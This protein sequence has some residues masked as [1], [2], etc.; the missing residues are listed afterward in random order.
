MKMNEMLG[1]VTLTAVLFGLLLWL[2][3]G[4]GYGAT[5]CAVVDVAKTVCDTTPVRYL[6]PDGKPQTE[7]VPTDEIRALAKRTRAARMQDAGANP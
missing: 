3:H 6:G 2:M 5:T 1:Q 4:C 7:Q